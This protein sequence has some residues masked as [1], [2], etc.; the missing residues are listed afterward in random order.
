M[1][2]AERGR[3]ITSI[4]RDAS[5]EVRMQLLESL[6]KS[7]EETPTPGYTEAREM[8]LDST[9][10]SNLE[11]VL[12]AAYAVRDLFE[13]K[14]FNS[15]QINTLLK[16]TGNDMAN[17]TVTLN[18]AIKSGW[19]AVAGKDGSTQQSKKRYSLTA[20]GETKARELLE[21]ASSKRSSTEL[22][23]QAGLNA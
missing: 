4:I 21:S 7:E 9:H 22:A 14:E 3:L 11:Q 15:L 1:E 16:E 5:D 10:L 8:L 2:D 23:P 20:A 19:V 12:L 13:L 6:T 17:I 18:G